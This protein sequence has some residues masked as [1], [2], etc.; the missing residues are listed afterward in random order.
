[1]NILQR[2]LVTE[3]ITNLN[4]KG[5]YGFVVACKA[6]KVAI[7]K[8]IEDCYGVRVLSVN[9]M[10]YAGKQK[11]RYTKSKV[12]K[13]KRAAYKKAVVTLKSGDIIDFYENIS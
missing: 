6:N 9:T 11:T 10:R 5:V 2:P 7:K 1:M 12:Q 8:E 3:K 13:G 4:E